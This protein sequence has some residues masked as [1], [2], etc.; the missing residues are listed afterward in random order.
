LLQQFIAVLAVTFL[1]LAVIADERRAKEALEL[2]EHQL[3]EAEENAR[4]RA[5]ELEV[6]LAALP[7]AVWVAQDPDCRHV[8]GNE[9]ARRILRLPQVSENMSKTAEDPTPVAH[10]KV[11]GG[12]GRELAPDE[13]P[14]Q[15]AARGELIR[16]FEERVEFSDGTVTDLLGSATPLYSPD[17]SVRGAVAAFIDITDRK[18]AELRE[19]F[20]A[21]EVDHRAK[22]IMAVLQSVVRLTK[23]NTVE[24]FREAVAGRIEAIARTH[25]LLAHNRWD[26]AELGQ[27]IRDELAAHTLDEALGTDSRTI[28]CAGPEIKLTPGSAQSIALVIHELVTNATK[29]GALSVAD[30]E[31]QVDWSIVGEATSRQLRLH[32]VEAKGPVVESPKRNG[33]GHSLIRNSVERQLNGTLTLDWNQDGLSLTIEVPWA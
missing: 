3:R 25:S 2:R 6:V 1:L 11:L 7:A 20:L 21:H 17:G 32:W 33:F 4:A 12:D 13:L 19:R 22:N 23:A 29:Y 24:G 15:R 9:Y 28:A 16:D 27:I 18:A 31:L 26:G 5:E 8:V 14:V 10:F 30:G